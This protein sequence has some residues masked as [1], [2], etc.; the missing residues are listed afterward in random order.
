MRFVLIENPECMKRRHEL[1]LPRLK[2][3]CPATL[4]LLACSGGAQ[5]EEL[6]PVNQQEL[7]DIV[8]NQGANA[9]FNH[10][11]EVGDELTE[12]TFT[13]AHGVGAHVGEG[14]RFSRFPRAD[15]DGRL[16]WT[17]HLPKREGGPN[18]TSCI[19]C[20]N[21]PIANGAGDIALNV[22]VDPGHT[23]D[24]AKYLERN[25]L[26]LMA[27]GVPQRLA[28]EMSQELFAQRSAMFMNTCKEGVGRIELTAKGVGFGSISA[29]R[30]TEAPCKIDVDYSGLSGVDEDLVI[31]A[32]GWKGNQP[33]IRAF[34]RNA[35]HN[36]LGL[37]AVELIGDKDGDFDGI[38]NELTVGDLTALTVYM[39][40]LERPVTKLELADLGLQELDNA[41]RARIELGEVQF[42]VAQCG[43]CHIPEMRLD[44]PV[45]SEPSAT[46]GFYDEMFPSGADP[47]EEY[48]VADAA[49][50][51]DMT[52]DQPNNR[53]ETANGEIRHL[54]ALRKASAGGALANWY[55]DFKRHDMGPHLADPDDPL[56]I[57]AEMWL[58]R[59]L[60]GVGS[61]G[62]WMHD[63]SATTLDEAIRMHAGEGAAS[64]DA[65]LA[66]PE[67]DRAAIV[68][69]LENLVIYKNEEAP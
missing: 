3:L 23:A 9:A 31:K 49:I 68:A 19:A 41:E 60:A 51:M 36:E 4:V 45:F 43:T 62:P 47:R 42:A 56:G 25:T 15:L 46:P 2:S 26:P 66:L 63:G 7:N 53:I 57:G 33:T 5:A 12:F 55:T 20:H 50:W 69:F 29:T 58:T 34:T 14:R 54:G 11:F 13:S 48:L 39:A 30:L 6:N 67:A 10:A 21:L 59:S 17:K 52:A 8:I 24:P 27:L 37:Q 44:N 18:A 65:Y 38:T 28:E 64:R 16:E 32:F 22:L 61:T 35:A 40:G 1:T